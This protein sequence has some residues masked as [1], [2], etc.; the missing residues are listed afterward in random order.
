M[1]KI[2]GRD[3]AM[4][5]EQVLAA[6]GI[7]R[8][9]EVVELAATARLDLAA[10]ATLLQKES[11]GG[12]NVF[13]HDPV[14]TGGFYVKGAEVTEDAY[15]NYKAHRAQL[16]CQG[17]GPTQLT[18]AAFQ[19]QADREGG[20]FD[21]RANCKVGFGILAQNIAAQGVREGFRA[22]NGSGPAAEAYAND[23]MGKLAVW[24]A[25]LRSGPPP[26]LH[27]GDTGPAVAAL[28]AFLNDT[29][30]L[31]SH[32]DVDQQY[33]PLTAAVVAEF[34]RRAGVTG[35]GVDADGRTVGPVT[36][37]ALERFGFH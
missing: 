14:N 33:G 20:C 6:H 3:H 21:W 23:A 25:R 13:G 11:G 18:L 30:P 29:F 8:P 35:P 10:A 4:T 24:Q 26:T 15:K 27:E 16:G 32:L 2:E 28:Q 12:Q 34:Q 9:A 1:V 17:V 36:L 37:A 31:Y 7:Q 22:Y 5:A 19:D